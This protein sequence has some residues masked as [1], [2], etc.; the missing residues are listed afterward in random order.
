MKVVV[1]ACDKY[2]W[3]IPT[4]LHFY[5]K[6]W[7][8]NP[9][10]TEFVT[11]TKKLDYPNVFYAGKMEWADRA[12]KYLK[13]STEDKFLFFIDDIVITKKIDTSKI[14]IAENFCKN[15]IGCVKLTE[16]NSWSKF[17]IGDGSV[18]Y[19]VYPS[20]KSYSMCM[21]VAIWQK[22]YFLGALRPGENIWQNAI[23]GSKRMP[24]LN[25]KIIWLNTP[26]VEYW[27]RGYMRVGVIVGHV[28]K[29]VKENW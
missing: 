18:G 10:E 3:L 24:K 9:Y 6:N 23:Q 8:D 4:F 15:E 20:N 12:I 29:W 19:K 7:P 16:H 13:Q 1:F 17:L 28:S 11:E 5:Q 2:A 26:I 22:S 25:K 14:K 21:Q 27:P